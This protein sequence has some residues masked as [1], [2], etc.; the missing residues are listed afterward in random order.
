M[1]P[2]PC[3][4]CYRTSL[5]VDLL[6]APKVRTILPCRGRD[7]WYAPSGLKNYGWPVATH[8]CS[9]REPIYPTDRTMRNA[10]R[11]NVPQKRSHDTIFSILYSLFMKHGRENVVDRRGMVDKEIA[12]PPEGGRAIPVA[13][14][15]RVGG[16]AYSAISRTFGP[17]ALIS[18]E[19]P[20]SYFLKFSTK[21]RASLAACS[22]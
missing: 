22:S 20:S 3:T 13:A 2:M 11:R 17:A 18:S 7:E 1:G 8:R 5:H 10:T 6:P 16:T 21:R 15:V 19:A 12:R 9:L 14:V 4:A